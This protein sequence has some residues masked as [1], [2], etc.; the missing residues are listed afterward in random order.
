MRV[1]SPEVLGNTGSWRQ[2][3]QSVSCWIINRLCPNA[4]Q[5]W[6]CRFCSF[7]VNWNC[8]R[9]RRSST[10]FTCSELKRI[11]LVE[12]CSD[13][14][15]LSHIFNLSKVWTLKDSVRRWNC[16]NQVDM[17]HNSERNAIILHVA[18]RHLSKC[19]PNYISWWCTQNLHCIICHYVL[20]SHFFHGTQAGLL[21]GVGE[22]VLRTRRREMDGWLALLE[23]T[24]AARGFFLF[25]LQQQ[26]KMEKSLCFL[27][28]VLLLGGFLDTAL[29]DDNATTESFLTLTNGTAATTAEPVT[30]Q[31]KTDPPTPTTA[32]SKSASTTVRAKHSN[33]EEDSSE[34]EDSRDDG[35]TGKEWLTCNIRLR[36]SWKSDVTQPEM[37]INSLAFIFKKIFM[38]SL[39][40]CFNMEAWKTGLLIKRIFTSLQS[41]L[42]PH[43]I[44]KMWDLL[45]WIIFELS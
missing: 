2:T 26:T 36:G 41:L 16:H 10:V 20:E 35:K 19:V 22:A 29:M 13:R 42:P 15:H 11:W 37:L 23:S 6:N 17:W 30:L 12:V 21:G 31:L 8:T 43:F 40:M 44:H 27:A 33:R 3:L 32:P 25:I 39:F 38:V 9:C 24:K 1:T 45:K 34:E 4:E 7:E 18:S 28:G 5:I 14:M